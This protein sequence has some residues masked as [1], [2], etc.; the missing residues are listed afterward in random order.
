MRLLE[1]IGA[2]FTLYDESLDEEAIAARTPQTSRKVVEQSDDEPYT[3][4]M[5]REQS[6]MLY[7]AGGLLCPTV[8]LRGADVHGE[9]HPPN[10]P[11]EAALQPLDFIVEDEPAPPAVQE[12]TIETSIKDLLQQF[13]EGHLHM[14]SVSAQLKKL[15]IHHFKL[16]KR[17]E[18]E[19]VFQIKT[20]VTNSEGGFTFNQINTTKQGHLYICLDAT[21]DDLYFFYIEGD[22]MHTLLRAY[23][24]Y[25][26]SPKLKGHAVR[27]SNDKVMYAFKANPT[28]T[29]SKDRFAWN[30]LNNH[31]VD[32]DDLLQI[33]SEHNV[34]LP[35][36][37][38]SLLSYI[39]KH[40]IGRAHV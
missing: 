22:D 31:R 6:E 34:I 21:E 29:A 8:G 30:Y 38:L 23:A 4:K 40:K 12:T 9:R 20:T 36:N 39:Y 24:H 3:P 25:Q 32:T 14:A 37:K 11:I 18:L 10:T 15:L 35:E 5:N 28:G 33:F 17:S 19:Q 1:E 7:E 26:H 2:R 16:R 13:H 27:G